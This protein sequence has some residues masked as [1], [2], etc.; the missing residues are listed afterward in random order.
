MEPNGHFDQ[1]RLDTA[2]QK[3]L[4]I[5]IDQASFQRHLARLSV[6]G[7]ADL[8]SETLPGASVSLSCVP[9]KSLGLAMAPAEFVVGGARRD[10]HRVRAAHQPHAQAGLRR[11]EN[12]GEAGGSHGEFNDC[13]T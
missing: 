10:A 1:E 12:H 3:T 2:K 7:Q 5:A 4:S 6:S 9:S 8:R 11:G 13:R